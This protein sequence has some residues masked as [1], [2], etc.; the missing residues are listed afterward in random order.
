MFN[1][2]IAA[3]DRAQQYERAMALARDMQRAGVTGNGVTQSVSALALPAC[4][5]CCKCAWRAL[6][7]RTTRG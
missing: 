4:K 7:L 5:R 6:W 3:C 2:L 1:A